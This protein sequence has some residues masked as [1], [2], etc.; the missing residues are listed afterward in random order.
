MTKE[1]KQTLLR[2]LCARL[3]YGVK[4]RASY[5]KFPTTLVDVNV[6]TND[7]DDFFVVTVKLEKTGLNSPSLIED[8]RP[9][10]RPM[11]S[12]TEEEKQKYY[13]L[14]HQEED[15]VWA[16]CLFDKMADFCNERHLD[17]RGLIPMGLALEAPPEMYDEEEPEEESEVPTPRTVDEAVKTLAK[18]VSKEDRD[19][20]LEN[21][22]ISMH[23]SLG[24]WIRNE[25]GLWTDSELK[26]ELRKK[27]FEHPD[28]MSNY[29]I[30]EFIKYWNNK[31]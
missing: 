31:I 9:Y 5:N 15:D 30:E 28:D 24:R 25:W 27:G 14:T 16:K 12:M 1:E 21:G 11:S 13:D 10:L 2:D 29:I 6:G 19:Y 22:A 17:Y 20:L 3:P 7:G 8:I 4:C 26:N 23:H 18:I